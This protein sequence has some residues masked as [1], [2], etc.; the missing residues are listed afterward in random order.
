[1]TPRK[2]AGI[3]A[4]SATLLVAGCS[5]L[6]G[7]PPFDVTGA[8]RG[9]W[10]GTLLGDGRPRT[11]SMS[12][13]LEHDGD[14][15]LLQGYVLKGT[16]TVYFTCPSLFDDIAD[17]GLPVR[18]STEVTGYVTRS[19]RITLVSAE[20]DSDTTLAISIR[21]AGSDTNDN[22]E[23]D[24]LSGSWSLAVKVPDHDQFS[25]SGTVEAKRN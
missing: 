20:T 9:V 22:G 19:G 3:A 17:D 13:S 16:A 1:M 6:G 23:M 11:C 12:L 25:L 4:L 24:A 18:L 21:G 14:Y 7:G 10:S 2:A 15:S 8:Y 5:W